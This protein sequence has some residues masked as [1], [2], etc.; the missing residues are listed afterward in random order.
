MVHALGFPSA[1]WEALM[2]ETEGNVSRFCESVRLAVCVSGELLIGLRFSYRGDTL[3]ALPPA[4]D[5]STNDM[6]LPARDRL[7]MRSGG[8][9]RSRSTGE[10]CKMLPALLSQT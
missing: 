4:Q 7:A 10:F 2:R 5:F 6:C 3:S 1:V 9:V 8:F